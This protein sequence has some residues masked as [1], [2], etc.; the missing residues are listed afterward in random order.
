MRKKPKPIKNE[1]IISN[2]HIKG[3]LN[4]RYGLLGYG[5]FSHLSINDGGYVVKFYKV[6]DSWKSKHIISTKEIITDIKETDD[7]LYLLLRSTWIHYSFV[8][9]KFIRDNL[10]SSLKTKD[11]Q[12]IFADQTPHKKFICS[13]CGNKAISR[14]DIILCGPCGNLFCPDCWEKHQWSHGKSPA[15]G[16]SYQADGSFS[17]FDGSE[18]LK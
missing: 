6:N 15:I 5:G 10:F 1:Q 7:G 12:N 17:G 2:D 3:F 16:I 8:D 14:E 4:S 9:N 13:F 11:I 18:R